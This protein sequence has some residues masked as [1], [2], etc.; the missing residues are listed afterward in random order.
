[1]YI[2]LRG[3]KKAIMRDS[4]MLTHFKLAQSNDMT[5]FSTLATVHIMILC[6]C[7]ELGG[8]ARVRF[9]DFLG[10]VYLTLSPG[11]LSFVPTGFPSL[12][13][14]TFIYLLS[15]CHM[16]ALCACGQNVSEG[17]LQD[18]FSSFLQGP[19]T[20]TGLHSHR[21]YLLSQHAG[22]FFIFF[23]I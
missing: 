8:T 21:F 16:G 23:L 5:D 1:M 7:G 15:P 18:S 10:C 9:G 22:P 3:E 4:F 6:V 14:F 19:S 13:T 2:T 20:A 12:K 17:N 11:T